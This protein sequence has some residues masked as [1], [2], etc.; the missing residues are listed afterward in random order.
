MR[1]AQ[2]RAREPLPPW[3]TMVAGNW[4]GTVVIVVQAWK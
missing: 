3:G 4:E 2:K 1:A